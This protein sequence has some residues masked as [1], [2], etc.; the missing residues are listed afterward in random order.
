MAGTTIKDVAKAAGVSI[1]TVSRVLS[2]KDP[3]SEGVRGRVLVAVRD[4]GYRP[5]ALARS[6]R[7]ET[8]RTLGLVVPNVMNPFFTS[9]ARAVEDAASERGYSVILCNAEE[10]PAKEESYLDVLLQKRVDGLVISPARKRSPQLGEFARAGVP[11]VFVDRATED[12]D[13]PTVRVDGRGA[14][15]ELVGYL[16]GLGHE[17][18]AVISGPREVIPG[19]ERLESFLNS[20]ETRGLR[21]PAEYLKLGD[22]RRESGRR[23]MRE[24]MSLPRPPSAIF[25]ANNLMCL[26]A[27]QAAKEGG[28]AIPDDVSIASFDDIAWFELLDPPITAIAQPTE[29][30][31]AIAAGTLLSLLGEDGDARSV[32]LEAT[33]TIR[34]SCGVP[35]GT[36]LP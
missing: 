34:G 35:R 21:L 2:G 7:E 11:V 23:A 12:L 8:T 6:L 31:G 5:N 9:V 13:V 32:S 27:L 29:K 17:R 16:V 19:K 22:F 30:L 33:L 26:G 15:D 36:V 25:V 24:L 28:H 14:V 1:A 20:A 10:D 4:L 3:V 18:L